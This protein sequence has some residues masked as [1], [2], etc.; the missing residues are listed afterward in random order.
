VVASPNST[1]A[2]TVPLPD[3]GAVS[4]RVTDA[5]GHPLR[6][7]VVHVSGSAADDFDSEF[8]DLLDDG[9][10]EYSRTD[11]SGRY[12]I[13]S[14]APGDSTVCMDASRARGGTSGAGYADQCIGGQPGG[15]TDG[16]PVPVEA[17]LTVAAPTLALT[18]TS[19]ISGTISSIGKSRDIEVGV[20]DDSG[21]Y[22]RGDDRSRPGSYSITGLPAGSYRVCV[23]DRHDARCYVDAPWNGRKPPSDAT[24][25]TTGA[26]KVT[27]GIDVTMHR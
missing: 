15:R 12:T 24:V 23:S 14:V 6:N 25:V 26:G 7:V 1:T 5:A 21:N 11:A 20:F 17:D 18:S 3:G 27:A 10:G 4:G 2:V 16:T 22:V 13:R 9:P 19:G 8:G